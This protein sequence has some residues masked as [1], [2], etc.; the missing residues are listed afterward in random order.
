MAQPRGSQEWY[1]ATDRSWRS[2][3]I[4]ERLSSTRR[5]IQSGFIER[6]QS[7]GSGPSVSDARVACRPTADGDTA[8]IH[9]PLRDCKQLF[10]SSV[11]VRYQS[12]GGRRHLKIKFFESLDAD[13][14]AFAIDSA[15]CN[16]DVMTASLGCER[17]FTDC[18]CRKQEINAYGDD[19]CP[20]DADA[21]A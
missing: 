18:F 15:H 7:S 11:T 13:S 16:A 12:R 17:T 3:F 8:K 1:W 2:C 9:C 6:L 10:K 21:H 5:G 14:G 4:R 19:G 20:G